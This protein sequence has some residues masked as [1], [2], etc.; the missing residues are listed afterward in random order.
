MSTPLI[1]LDYPLEPRLVE[2]PRA[3][4]AA[5]KPRKGKANA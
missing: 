2:A 4:G 5:E 1:D 3:V